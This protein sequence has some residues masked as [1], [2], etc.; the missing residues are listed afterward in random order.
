MP[1]A[2]VVRVGDAHFLYLV[3]RTENSLSYRKPWTTICTCEFSQL[4]VSRFEDTTTQIGSGEEMGRSTSW[5]GS[6][7]WKNK[8]V[9]DGKGELV[10]LKMRKVRA[11]CFEGKGSGTSEEEVGYIYIDAFQAH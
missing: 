2:V 9:R 4:T 5:S 8:V 11:C 6:D 1:A 10:V 3:R 7:S